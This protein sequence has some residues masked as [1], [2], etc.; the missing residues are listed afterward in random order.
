MP[1]NFNEPTCI[2]Y[3]KVHNVTKLI[4]YNHYSICG[5]WQRAGPSLISGEVLYPT[6]KFYC[7]R[8]SL[9]VWAAVVV[10]RPF[11]N[12]KWLIYQRVAF[13][14][15]SHPLQELGYTTLVPF[16]SSWTVSP[17]HLCSVIQ[18]IWSPSHRTTCCFS[19]QKSLCHLVYSRRRI[20]F[21]VVR[22]SKYNILRIFS[23]EDGAGNTFP[24]WNLDKSGYALN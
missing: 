1:T 7:Q 24:L 8:H 9:K 10:R 3:Y 18:T 21:L 6:R 5:H 13:C 22:G 15:T 23:G 14:Q 11:V 17:S 16:M 12:R 4:I 2:N 19:N 20:Y